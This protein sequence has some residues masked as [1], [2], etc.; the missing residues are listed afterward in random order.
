MGDSHRYKLLKIKQAA[1]RLSPQDKK[2]LDTIEPGLASDKT[3]CAHAQAF[4]PHL[5]MVYCSSGLGVV[6]RA[7][8]FL[9]DWGLVELDPCR[10]PS[11]AHLSSSL[12]S[13]TIFSFSRD[14]RHSRALGSK[15]GVQP[16]H[17]LEEILAANTSLV[18]R[19]AVFK[20]GRTTGRTFGEVNQIHPSMAVSSKADNNKTITCVGKVV[21]IVRPREESQ[22]NSGRHAGFGDRG[23]SGSLVFD[24]QGQVMGVYFA[25][26]DNHDGHN[27]G[28]SLVDGIHLVAPIEPTLESI[29]A[30]VQ[31]DPEL[32]GPDFAEV[33]FLWGDGEE[34]A[35]GGI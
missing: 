30:T 10:F 8:G 6:Q 27:L 34:S 24:Y 7:S 17:E 33:E 29:R 3:R 21:L 5:G 23:D 11:F 4:E 19:K 14:A 26:K 16:L 1:E 9:L 31:E 13:E 20:V 22:E 12:D 28:V 15:T 35:G 25:G 2:L 18:N 32:F